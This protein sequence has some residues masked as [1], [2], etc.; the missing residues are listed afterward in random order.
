[1]YSRFTPTILFTAFAVLLSCG[2][3]AQP[4]PAKPI[5]IIVGAGSGGGVDTISRLVA[6]KLDEA[7]HQQVIVEDKPGAGGAVASE[8]VAKAPADG[9]TLLTMSISYA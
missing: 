9:H 4:Y 7:W 8:L 5:R 3:F 1:M 2:A 6:Q